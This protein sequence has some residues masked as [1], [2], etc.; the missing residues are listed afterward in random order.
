MAIYLP[1]ALWYR[2]P[3]FGVKGE[4]SYLIQRSFWGFVCFTFSYY[5]LSYVSLSDA[6]AIAFSAP[7]FVS[8]FACVLLKEPCGV[9]QITTI[10][11]TL[12]GVFLIARPSFIFGSEAGDKLFSVTDRII[13]T[14]LSF[15]TALT[16][17]YTFVVIRRLQQTPTT[18]VINFFSMFTIVAGTVVVLILKYATSFP[19]RMPAQKDIIF[20]FI[21]GM[22]GVVGQ[23]FLVISLK[24]EQ[25]GLVSLTRTFDIVMAFIYQVACLNQEAELMSIIGAVI[26]SAGCVACGLKKFLEA[27]PGALKGFSISIRGSKKS[28]TV[29]QPLPPPVLITCDDVSS[30]KK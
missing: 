30:S 27:K 6:S 14:S 8:I 18:T 7:V 3:I 1:L 5:S 23:G 22:C 16:M 9:F 4:R 10:V 20:L 26:V 2:D 25:A 19:V 24:I 11:C 29:N 21:N 13:G 28:Y 12:V 17:A 15:L